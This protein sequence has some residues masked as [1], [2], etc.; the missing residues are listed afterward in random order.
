MLSLKS[1]PTMNSVALAMKLELC[2]IFM[3]E[4]RKQHVIKNNKWE[5]LG[6]NPPMFPH[7]YQTVSSLYICICILHVGVCLYVGR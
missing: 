7:V 1:A 2:S 6:H 3:S 5:W 4:M